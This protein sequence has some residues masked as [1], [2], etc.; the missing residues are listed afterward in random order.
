MAKS[1]D[2]PADGEPAQPSIG[3]PELNALQGRI[4]AL[5]AQLTE[6]QSSC[7][8]LESEELKDHLSELADEL[9]R[10][11]VQL[12][13]IRGDDL[14]Q[15]AQSGAAKILENCAFAFRLFAQGDAELN[16]EMFR[17][18]ASNITGA[19]YVAES[20]ISLI[21]IEQGA[22]LGMNTSFISERGEFGHERAR[23]FASEQLVT[24]LETAHASIAE[25]ITDDN[26][27]D[28]RRREQI[29]VAGD[30]MAKTLELIAAGFDSRENENHF[31]QMFRFV[32]YQLHAM[33]KSIGKALNLPDNAFFVER[34]QGLM[35]AP[36][37]RH[38]LQPVT[39]P[40]EDAL[41][42]VGLLQRVSLRHR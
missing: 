33:I 30:R 2:L 10:I 6:R 22:P 35:M 9:T 1:F 39:Q 41:L 16:G 34:A 27:L 21:A 17:S 26:E 32:A 42:L 12:D 23:R 13:A 15:K 5:R 29:I 25:C 20:M 19:I 24:E 4:V 18:I 37:K 8:N 31:T 7:D 38:P 36:P 14:E 11:A 40:L 3:N 28:P